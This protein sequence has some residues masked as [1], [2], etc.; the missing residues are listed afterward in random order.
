[1]LFRSLEFWNGSAWIEIHDSG[2]KDIGDKIYAEE[3][4]LHSI[5]YA[6]STTTDAQFFVSDF[7]FRINC[8]SM[9]AGRY[10]W[11]DQAGVTAT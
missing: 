3:T 1:M 6:W 2:G 8:H 11:L 9:D 10:F 5:D 4:W 7:K